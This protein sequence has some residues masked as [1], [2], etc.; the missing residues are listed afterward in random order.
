MGTGP[1]YR[2]KVVLSILGANRSPLFPATVY[3]APLDAA[4]AEPDGYTRVAIASDATVWAASGDGAANIVPIAAG[5][6]GTGWPELTQ[7]ALFDS[8]TAGNIILVS[9]ID[10]VTPISGAELTVPVGGLLFEAS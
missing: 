5:T 6:A 1:A 8:A 9:A 7:H 3:Y 10:P 2:Q 4:G